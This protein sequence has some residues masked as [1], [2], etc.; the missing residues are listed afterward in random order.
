MKTKENVKNIESLRAVYFAVVEGDNKAMAQFEKAVE[1]S[2]ILEK[3]E[4][5]K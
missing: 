5:K 2:E 4:Q 1:V 3:I